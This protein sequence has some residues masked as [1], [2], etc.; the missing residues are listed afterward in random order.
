[1]TA[2]TQQT[3]LLM[4][5]GLALTGIIS[6]C[7]AVGFLGGTI[8]DNTST[9]ERALRVPT[10]EEFRDSSVA[11]ETGE[12]II[13][14]TAGGDER[15]GV[16]AGTRLIPVAVAVEQ[17]DA[18]LASGYATLPDSDVARLGVP[19]PMRVSRVGQK[20]NGAPF[21]STPVA[22]VSFGQLPLRQLEPS[23]VVVNAQALLLL[24]D[25]GPLTVPVFEISAITTSAP[26]KTTMRLVILGA[27]TDFV[28]LQSAL[29]LLLTSS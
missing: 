23:A 4:V 14:G 28:L 21:S 25:E 18:V 3:V 2:M 1:M 5:T 19:P 27:I 29:G 13:I 24:A 16:Y 9:E 22:D 11:L 6:G 17:L 26:K 12:T 8:I 20:P 15:E 7:S 10:A